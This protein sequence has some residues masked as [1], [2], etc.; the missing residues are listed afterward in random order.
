M[1][2]SYILEQQADLRRNKTLMREAEQAEIKMLAEKK[3]IQQASDEARLKAKLARIKQGVAAPVSVAIEAP[4][5]V[6]PKT[7]QS[8]P[9]AKVSFRKKPVEEETSDAS[10]EG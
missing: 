8:K 6:A 5:P 4:S 10:E 3:N 7:V 9:K 2:T 1:T